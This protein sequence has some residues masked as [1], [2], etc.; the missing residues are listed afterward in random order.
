M[1]KILAKIAIALCIAL[2]AIAIAIITRDR[3]TLEPEGIHE[4]TNETRL[5]EE[6]SSANP[7]A[8][9]AYE[10]TE[11]TQSQAYD[12]TT[13][14]ES[15]PKQ[16]EYDLYENEAEYP[17]IYDYVPYPAED[18]HP[19]PRL[20]PSNLQ[21]AL[22]AHMAFFPFDFNQGH[23][24][25]SP[26]FTPLHYQPFSTFIMTSDVNTQN[27][28]GFS[29][30]NEMDGWHLQQT[31][32]DN[33]TGFSATMYSCKNNETVVMAFRGS[34]GDIAM[35]LLTQ[36][37]TWWCN[38]QSLGGEQHSH[39]GSLIAFLN[40]AETQAMLDGANIYITGHS[41]GGYLAYVA[42]YELVQLGFEDNIQR[43]VAFS[44]PIFNTSTVEMIGRLQPAT[45]SK[46]AHFYVPYDLISGIVGVETDMYDGLGVFELTSRVLSTLR[47]VRGVDVP[48]AVYGLSNLMVSVEG[49]LP[50][51]MPSA[52][53]GLIWQLYGAMGEDA[54]AITNE[55]R[56]LIYHEAVAHTWHTP[57]PEPILA[58]DISVFDIL[59]N[60]TPELMMEI[61][62]DMIV[63][64][65]DSD[66]HF[67]M[68]FYE[69][70]GGE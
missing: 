14:V 59:L 51:D 57:R 45:R 53:S 54:L 11:E 52:I 40:T 12:T 22:F 8:Y 67:M 26:Q 24:P 9:N 33:T 28:Y 39:A 55:F 50:F 30:A 6:L 1:K 7:G 42:T 27:Q 46:I 23:R 61:A 70:L 17:E 13:I 21:L 47:D 5:L 43:V 2:V 29:F 31:Y 20:S 37:G 18:P 62:M 41:L 32:Y 65:F 36:S 56:R 49:I 63:R 15:F 3:G 38:M 69:H 66:T 25:S 4:Y 68:N 34:Y 10:A 16:L 19:L 64:V 35:S 48:P 58:E 60:F 44:A